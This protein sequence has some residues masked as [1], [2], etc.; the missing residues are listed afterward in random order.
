MH[1]NFFSY[2]LPK[3]RRKRIFKK[4]RNDVIFIKKH[5]RATAKKPVKNLNSIEIGKYRHLARLRKKHKKKIRH[6]LYSQKKW[7]FTVRTSKYHVTTS[8]CESQRF[9]FTFICYPYCRMHAIAHYN[10]LLITNCS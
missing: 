2:L 9:S 4:Q 10:P 8:S 3:S 5:R 1:L 7:H 6:P